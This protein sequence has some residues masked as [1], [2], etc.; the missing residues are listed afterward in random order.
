MNLYNPFSIEGKT[1]LVTGA[2]SG[3][4]R[5]TA[6]E[7]SKAGAQLL[8]T[9][10]NK[11]RLDETFA[12]LEGNNHISV[13]ADLS[14]VEGIKSLLKSI[15]PLDGAV[16]C[17][18]IGE[19]ALIPFCNLKKFQKIFN[20]NLFSQTELIRLLIKDKKCN[21]YASIVA[22][23]SIS[24]FTHELGN[25]IYGAGKPALSAWIKYAAFEFGNKGIRFN[26][27]CPGIIETPIIRGGAISDEQLSENMKEYPLGRFGKPEEI[28]YGAMYLLSDASA[29]VT[30][31]D[32]IID[33]GNTL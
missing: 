15:T 5:A 13:V 32:L 16:L 25:S 24:K 12:S 23:S 22:I 21:N 33:G 10:R 3:I 31:I 27:I 6:I 1:I 2:S 29:W 8:I 17:A 9:G 11:E 19:T 18:G 30:G 14:D 7:C 28:A 26:C 20:V 4:G